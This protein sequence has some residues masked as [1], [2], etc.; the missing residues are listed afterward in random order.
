MFGFL[1][2][3]AFFNQM[4]DIIMETQLLLAEDKAYLCQLWAIDKD[5]LINASVRS[6]NH[7]RKITGKNHNNFY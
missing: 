1:A 6:I 5:K 2:A 3:L 7:F 4:S